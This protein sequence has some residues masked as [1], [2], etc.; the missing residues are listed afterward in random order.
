MLNCF[1]ETRSAH[2]VEF[3]AGNPAIVT[4]HMPDLVSILLPCPYCSLSDGKTDMVLLA[5]SRSS[6]I[7]FW[8]CTHFVIF[9]LRFFKIP[10]SI[11]V[12][13]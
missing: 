8:E 11:V 6:E 9:F 4:C 2:W 12:E 7:N 10:K 3:D 5:P 13:Y 1:A